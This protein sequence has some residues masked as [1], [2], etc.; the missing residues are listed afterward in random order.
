MSQMKYTEMSSEHEKKV[1]FQNPD[2][3]GKIPTKKSAIYN[4]YLKTLTLV[5]RK[6]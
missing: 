3:V 4:Y 1:K 5:D 2:L 6:Y